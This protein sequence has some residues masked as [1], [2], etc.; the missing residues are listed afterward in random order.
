[1]KPKQCIPTFQAGTVAYRWQ[2]PA[3]LPSCNVAHHFGN[4][5]FT[6]SLVVWNDGVIVPV[7]IHFDQVA[8]ILMI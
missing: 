8:L 6:L 4:T 1:L 5:D 2:V 7:D 3:Y